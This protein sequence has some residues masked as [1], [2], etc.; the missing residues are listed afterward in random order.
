MNRC[1]VEEWTTGGEE[2]NTQVELRVMRTKDMNT[3]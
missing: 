2:K 3:P 1:E